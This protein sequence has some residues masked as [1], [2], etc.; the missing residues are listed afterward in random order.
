MAGESLISAVEDF[1]T[2]IPEASWVVLVADFEIDA[3][4]ESSVDRV[5]DFVHV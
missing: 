2:G 4:V 5:G 1:E 3:F